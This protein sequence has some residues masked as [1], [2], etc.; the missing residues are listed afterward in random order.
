MGNGQGRKKKSEK[1][2]PAL[3]AL[4]A[5]I[6]CK[7]PGAMVS[8]LCKTCGGFFHMRE[9]LDIHGG[10]RLHNSPR[11]ANCPRAEGPRN[12]GVCWGGKRTDGRPGC[13][14]CWPFGPDNS[15][16]PP[17][18]AAAKGLAAAAEHASTAAADAE[19]F[20]RMAEEAAAAAAQT[21]WAGNAA[22]IG[23]TAARERA[24][25]ARVLSRALSRAAHHAATE[26]VV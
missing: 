9:L 16:V 25:E 7:S 17:P 24:R 1:Y 23:A 4:P 12:Y 2:V 22:A 26:S 11:H 19:E 6:S 10:S 13:P 14:G 8:H 3:F 20:A 18:T 15:T 5:G 21:G